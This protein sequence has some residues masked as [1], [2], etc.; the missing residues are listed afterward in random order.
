MKFTI[1]RSDMERALSAAVAAL[2]SRVTLPVLANAL[3]QTTSHGIAICCTDLDLLI[4]T[5]ALADVE[6]GG[7]ACIPAKQLLELV[8][9]FSD[10]PIRITLEADRAHVTCGKNK[11][12]LPF[13]KA[14][15]FPVT[16]FEAAANAFPI[17]AR[18]LHDVAA[19]ITPFCSGE[20]SRPIL[21]GVYMHEVDGA[22]SFVATN[23]FSM[24]WLKAVD[25][26]A[27]A[28]FQAIVP[29]TAFTTAAKLFPAT[30]DVSVHRDG[31]AISFVSPQAVVRCRL[32]EGPF[33]NYT[34][35]IPR[36]FVGKL[37]IGISAVQNLMRRLIVVAP[38]TDGTP[39]VLDCA[40]GAVEFRAADPDRGSAI[41][42]V[43]AEYEGEP[44][45][46]A[47]NIVNIT[48]IAKALARSGASGMRVRLSST[49]R[50]LVA[51][52]DT[53]NPS[54]LFLTMPIRPDAISDAKMSAQPETVARK[55]KRE[56]AGSF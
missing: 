26:V 48:T 4:K 45:M 37:R 22:M 34:Q 19:A 43:E 50:P 51:E 27:P 56:T 53:D 25:T 49:M 1:M 12:R 47:F 28:K 30:I 10:A 35:I 31:N 46:L 20:P 18:A 23:G 52:P 42:Q 39:A 38:D 6:Q 55:G 21:N 32:L 8:R 44:I 24:G 9:S 40:P 17:P 36:D 13:V 33:P 41:E 54:W 5:E 3:I 14:E 2:P 15:E 7:Q 29:P 16:D 11:S